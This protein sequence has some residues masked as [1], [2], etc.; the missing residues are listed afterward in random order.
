MRK[1]CIKIQFVIVKIVKTKR[2]NKVLLTKKLSPSGNIRNYSRKLV[3][4]FLL[5]NWIFFQYFLIER[6]YFYSRILNS[7]WHS[8]FLIIIIA[9]SLMHLMHFKI[10]LHKRLESLNV[11]IVIKIYFK[12]SITLWTL[13]I[14]ILELR[15]L[16]GILSVSSHQM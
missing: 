1:Y 7:Y 16:D 4:F 2:Q 5:L 14:K 3:S 12:S 11:F 9:S 10:Y 13:C 15:S 8:N 6:G